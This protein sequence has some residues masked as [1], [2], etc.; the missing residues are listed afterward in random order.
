MTQQTPGLPRPLPLIDRDHEEWWAG[1]RRH[2]LLVQECPRCSERIFPPQAMCPHCRSTERSWHRLSPRGTVYSWVTVHRPSHPWFADK[3]PYAVVLVEME[4]GFR[5]VGS[6]DFPRES[7]R[8][9]LRVEAGF[10][11]VSEQLTLLRFRLAE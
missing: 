9:G 2:E 4:E 5:F 10:E 1:L 6:I 8:A 3:V 11:D 7:L